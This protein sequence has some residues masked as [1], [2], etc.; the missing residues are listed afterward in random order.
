[1]ET[2]QL[3]YCLYARKSSESDERQALSIDS[4]IKEMHDVATQHKLKIV[5]VKRESHSAKASGQRPEYNELIDGIKQGKFNAILTWAPDRLSRNAGDLGSIVDLMDSGKL[6]EIRTPGQSFS[7]NPNEKFLLMILCSQAKLENDNR[8]KNVLRGQKN[9]CEMGW[10]PCMAPLGY[11]N[12][13]YAPRGAQVV[14]VDPVR[15][16]II[17]EMFEQFAYHDLTGRRLLNWMN[18]EK[19]FR[20]RNE[21]KL[22]LSMVYNMLKNPFYYGEFEYPKGSGKFYQ[23][24]HEP[25]ISKELFMAA[26]ARISAPTKSIYGDKRFIYVGILKCGHCGHGITASEK[27]K[28]FRTG[29]TVRYVYYHCTNQNGVNNCRSKYL[30][31]D[32]LTESLMASLHLLKLDEIELAKKVNS[33]MRRLSQLTAMVSGKTSEEVESIGRDSLFNYFKFTLENGTDEEKRGVL[34]Y[35]RSQFRVKDGQLV[36]MDI[37]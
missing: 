27:I 14:F 23:G 9:K 35:V 15:A 20:T 11:L 22:T 4:Q 3:K 6:V 18:E 2:A 8:T 31:E 30:R 33:E 7:N 28:T 29:K 1:M 17:K 36:L 34:L 10:R 16:P 13:K 21:K 24:K 26:R 25:L 12:Q 37:S 5:A 32:R 19:L